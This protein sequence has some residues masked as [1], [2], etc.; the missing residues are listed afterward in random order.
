MN[1]LLSALLVVLVLSLPYW[2]PPLIIRLRMNIFTRINGEQAI[3]LP[4]ENFDADDFRELYAHP[5]MTGRS[6]GATLSDLFWY[7]LSPGPEMHPEHLEQG[8]RY[9]QLSRLTRQIMA[10]SRK[11]IEALIDQYQHDPLKLGLN[12]KRKW[13]HIRLRDM[14]MPLW[15][16]FFYQVVFKQPCSDAARK[17]IVD[18]A[19]DVVNALK[20]C[21]L[22]NMSKRDQLTRFILDKLEQGHFPYE[23][24][25]GLTRLEQAH[26]L[27]GAFFNTAIVQMSEAMAHLILA[28]AQHP[29]CQKQL[30]NSEDNHY[31]D[32][33]INESLRLNPL[34][35]IAH[36]IVTETVEF[37]GRTIPK[38][39]VV[40]FNYPEYHK[41][42]YDRPDQFNPERWQSC[43]AKDANFMP[44]GVSSNRSC[45]AQGIAMISM[46]KLARQLIDNYT[47]A[48]PIKHTR[49]MPNRGPCLV[50]TASAT[51]EHWL[52]QKAVF[53]AMKILDR[54]EDLY[55]SIIQLIFGTIMILHAKKL[56]LCEHYFDQLNNQHLSPTPSDTL[57]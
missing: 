28:I 38:N 9:Q 37:K 32:D 55:R 2:L 20:C 30:R 29:A 15:A 18:H 41:M 23:F 43:P 53:P 6:K 51:P 25:E 12:S 19:S 34:F 10:M 27:Q 17:L 4:D 42:G 56:K 46:R 35:G 36:R 54:W 5:A 1:I 16:D 31:L 44:F 57:H 21:K 11:D 39:T 26:Y 24:P 7:W 14:F 22:R 49:S 3:Q 40:C 13:T 47:F 45:P 8:E 48:S 50:M 33:V 52:I